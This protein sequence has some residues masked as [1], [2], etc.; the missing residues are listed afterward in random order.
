[1]RRC[2]IHCVALR[3]ET[4]ALPHPLEQESIDGCLAALHEALPEA[5]LA[6]ALAAGRAM[7][8]EE[9]IAFASVSAAPSRRS[10]RQPLVRQ[11]SAVMLF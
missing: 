4:G 5:D 2:H 8:W 1:M 11:L 9:A 6:A 10:P 7:G 3:K